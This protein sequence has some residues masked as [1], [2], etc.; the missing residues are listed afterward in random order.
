MSR[1]H[2]SHPT[3]RGFEHEDAELSKQISRRHAIALELDAPTNVERTM[4]VDGNLA[5]DV[6]KTDYRAEPRLRPLAWHRVG[7]RLPFEQIL[8]RQEPLENEPSL[9]IHCGTDT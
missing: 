7:R 6:A 9:A 3:T 5:V 4:D 8:P 2:V 1:N